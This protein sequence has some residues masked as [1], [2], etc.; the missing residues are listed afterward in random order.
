M[1]V[2]R[3]LFYN[4]F[5]LQEYSLD[6]LLLPAMGFARSVTEV[7]LLHA[8]VFL[9]I[10]GGSGRLFSDAARL[11]YEL[12]L[13]SRRLTL[14]SWKWGGRSSVS[15]SVAFCFLENTVACILRRWAY[16][17]HFALNGCGKLLCTARFQKPLFGYVSVR[18]MGG[19]RQAFPSGWRN[20]YFPPLQTFMDDKPKKRGI[21]IDK[22]SAKYL[23]SS[24]PRL[25]SWTSQW[26]GW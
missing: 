17:R 24:F 21:C 22:H 6:G 14:S 3:P 13:H 1:E 11:S 5:S 2:I 7:I 12:E 25:P 19:K 20:F 18:C 8:Q 26:R 23:A 15:Q 9:D 16:T 4:V 10:C